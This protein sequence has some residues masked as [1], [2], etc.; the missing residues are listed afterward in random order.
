MRLALIG[1]THFVNPDAEKIVRAWIASSIIRLNPSLIISGGAKGVDTWAEQA[2]DRFGIKK[3]IKEPKY[4][5]WAPQGFKQRNIMIA[6]V[7]THLI[8]W[9]CPL[10][11][12][13]GS[14]WTADYA[15]R[16]GRDVTRHIVEPGS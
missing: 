11:E 15:E 9:R 14:G 10:S 16:I 5:Q 13:Y 4:H 7:C 3:N 12:T 6:E 2:A 8:A 1:S